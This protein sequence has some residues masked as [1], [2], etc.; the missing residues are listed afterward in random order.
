MRFQKI[1]T[2]QNTDGTLTATDSRHPATLE[3][4]ASQPLFANGPAVGWISFSPCGRG[5]RTHRHPQ[6]SLHVIRGAEPGWGDLPTGVW[7]RYAPRRI[8][9]RQLQCPTYSAIPVVIAWASMRPW[10]WRGARR[11]R[12]RM[13]KQEKY[14]T[15]KLRGKGL[16]GGTGLVVTWQ[17]WLAGRLH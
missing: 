4:S 15:I 8:V 2:G 5:A 9:S 11:R 3:M 1:T 14:I 10:R 7:G 17:A 13:R 16:V 6:N 12:R